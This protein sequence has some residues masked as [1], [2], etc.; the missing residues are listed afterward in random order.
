MK[1]KWYDYLIAY[2]F[3]GEGYLTP[4]TGT[5]IISRVSKINNIEELESARQF[6]ESR[7]EG[8]SNLAITNIVLLGR[9]RHE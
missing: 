3:T 1:R 9:N 7:I 4:C 6:I 5:T 8:A 2:V